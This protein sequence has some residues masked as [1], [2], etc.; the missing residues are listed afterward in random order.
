MKG[1][2]LKKS[3]QLEEICRKA[4]VVLEADRAME[5]VIDAMKR[6]PW[7]LSLN[8][9]SIKLPGMIIDALVEALLILL[10]AMLRKLVL[11]LINFQMTLPRLILR[12]MFFSP[13]TSET[14]TLNLQVGDQGRRYSRRDRKEHDRN[15]GSPEEF[16]LGGGRAPSRKDD[17][18]M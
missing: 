8:K 16:Y 11:R 5:Y 3:S 17:N 15:E 9:L 10:P 4:N 1:F 14:A 7:F 12:Y 13:L 2:V 18:G 6:C